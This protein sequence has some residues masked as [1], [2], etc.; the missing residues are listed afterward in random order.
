MDDMLYHELTSNKAQYSAKIEDKMVF[1]MLRETRERSNDE[2][3][4]RIV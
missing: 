2:Y 3:D 1:G 4:E